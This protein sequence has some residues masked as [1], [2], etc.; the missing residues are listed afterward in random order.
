MRRTNAGR[1]TI[2]LA[3]DLSVRSA[4]RAT[5]TTTPTVSPNAA[6]ALSARSKKRGA[7]ARNRVRLLRWGA[8]TAILAAL[9][10][11]WQLA[12]GRVI[13]KLFISSPSDIAEAFGRWA[14]DGTLLRDGLATLES[15]VIGFGIGG[16]AALI[17]GYTL[18]VSKTLAG[19]VEPF[20]TALW[21]LPRIALIPLLMIWVG[22]GSP[23]AIAIA[24]IL[25]FF[26][27]FYNTFYGI[28]DVSQALINSVRIMGGNAGDIAFRV[29][30][31]SALVWIAAGVKMSL[32]MALVGVVTAEMLGSNNGLGYLVQF[33]ANSFDT[34]GTFAALLALLILG[35]ALERLSRLVS[36]K[37]LAWKGNTQP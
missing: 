26:L 18:G 36:S 31:P 30:L 37:A 21:G 24:A 14:G 35:V 9:I 6:T 32:P 29:R 7:G 8:Q 5:E 17:V 2:A 20:I 19:I 12:A 3:P 33:A 23:L 27:L 4:D 25:S 16:A 10:G 22:V 1:S 34:A 28:R 15:T 13:S 11:L